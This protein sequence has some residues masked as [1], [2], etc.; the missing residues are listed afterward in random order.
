VLVVDLDVHQGDGTADLLRA[1]DESFLLSV[2]GAANFPF[3]R[4]PADLDVDLPDRTGDDAYLAALAPAL[5][6]ALARARPDLV[7]YAAGADPWAGDRL[8]R[9]A[10]SAE[11]LARRDAHVVERCRQA[12]LPL[13]VV[14]AGGYGEPIDGTV[15]IHRRTLVQAAALAP[16]PAAA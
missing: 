15:A 14:L 11:G 9:L 12:G 6:Q 10:L 2:Q 13:V 3:K 7:A 1:D 5:E 16:R 4:I 8:G